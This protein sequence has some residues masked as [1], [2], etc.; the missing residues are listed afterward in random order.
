MESSRIP[1]RV[2]LQGMHLMCSSKKGFSAN[3]LRRILG[4]ILKSA[5]FLGHRIRAAMTD[6]GV[7]PMGGA[8]EFVE[9]DQTFIGRKSTSRAYKPPGEK[10]AV[11]ALV[12]HGGG[13]RSFHIPNVTAANIRPIIAKHAHT[14]SSFQT[15]ESNA[16][17]SYSFAD[18]GVVNHSQKQYVLGTDYTN[19][20]EGHFLK[21]GIY[22][23]YQH[24]S[25]A[26]LHRYLAEFDFHYTNR[27]ATGFND[28][29]RMEKALMG[30]AGKMLTYRQAGGGRAAG[31]SA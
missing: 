12:Q 25:E 26:H 29:E 8:G 10:Q 14:D 1:L 30:I 6:L 9:A 7:E 11:L 22:G 27:I 24:V 4:I 13:V 18:R 16:Y 5:W 17:G 19:T 23:I 2:W 21:R 15:H 20:I 3:Q 31:A 28:T